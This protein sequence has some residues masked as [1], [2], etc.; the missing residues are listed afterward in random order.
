M[1]K[2][3]YHRSTEDE[4]RPKTNDRR[5]SLLTQLTDLQRLFDDLINTHIGWKTYAA[6][7]NEEIP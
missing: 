6:S 5:T 3:E 2:I 1:I 4:Q 7:L